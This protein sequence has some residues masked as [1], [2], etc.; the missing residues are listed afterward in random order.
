MDLARLRNQTEEE[1]ECG[2]FGYVGYVSSAGI[3]VTCEYLTGLDDS[4]IEGS[5]PMT[6]LSEGKIKYLDTVV[7]IMLQEKEMTLKRAFKHRIAKD[8]WVKPD[9]LQYC[10]KKYKERSFQQWWLL[11]P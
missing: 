2:F 5:T 10:W 11:I 9:G 6:T 8:W 3:L 4:L 1:G 7:R